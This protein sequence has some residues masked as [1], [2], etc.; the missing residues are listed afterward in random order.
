VDHLSRKDLKTDQISQSAFGALDW[1]E[2]HRATVMKWA[3]VVVGIAVIALGVY[4]YRNYQAGVRQEA[5]ANALRIDEA[6]VGGDVQPSQQHFATEEEKKAAW[7]KA[8]NALANDYSGTAEG[9]IADMYLGGAAAE[10]GDLAQAEKRFKNTVDNAP[11]NYAALAR[12]SLADIYKSEGKTAEAEKV[13]RDAVASPT[14]TVSKDQATLALGQLLAKSK[15]DEA[16]KLIQPLIASRTV[17]S[18]AAVNA[19]S[20]IPGGSNANVPFPLPAPEKK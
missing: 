15:P 20:E 7:D 2:H 3:G 18:R 4:F 17:I 5:L 13:L 6:T 10:K 19:M 9:A 1:A 16:R 11:A 12:L 8:F 14:A